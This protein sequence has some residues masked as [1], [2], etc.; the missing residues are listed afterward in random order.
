MVSKRL[1]ACLT[2]FARSSAAYAVTEYSVCIGSIVAV[3]LVTGSLLGTRL[4]STFSNAATVGLSPANSPF[5][6]VGDSAIGAA[7]SHSLEA[8]PAFGHSPWL[9][10]VIAVAGVAPVLVL[11]WAIRRIVRPTP[12]D[13][14]ASLPVPKELQAKFVAKRQAILHFLS[15]DTQQ[16]AHGKMAV[17]HIM[18]TTPMTR[19]PDDDVH[20][21]RKLMKES[22][23]RHLVVCSPTGAPVGVISDRDIDSRSGD[24]VSDIM[25]ANP[26]T[27]TP[28]TAVAVTATMMLARRINCVPVV[29]EGRLLGIV[30]TSDLLMALQCVLR[31][32]EQLSLPLE[33]DDGESES[34]NPANSDEHEKDGD[35]VVA[36][37]ASEYQHCHAGE[38]AFSV[39]E[40]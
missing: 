11:L 4:K 3:V 1:P 39:S 14:Q 38:Q 10:L 13:A 26:V 18:S 2:K 32:I 37:Q 12:R 25:T 21:L 29:E 23:I 30:T 28:D 19:S 16:L 20:E 24:H 34:D 17:R 35:L 8:S 6:H 33:H 27:V 7:A 36:E 31:L 15:A 40:S 22:V 5:G 9:W